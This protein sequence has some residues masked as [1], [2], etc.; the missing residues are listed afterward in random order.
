[1]KQHTTCIYKIF[2]VGVCALLFSIFQ[3]YSSGA[4][5]VT[6]LPSEVELSFV[7]S[8]DTSPSNGVA[9]TSSDLIINLPFEEQ[10]I[11]IYDITGRVWYRTTSTGEKQL[12]ISRS[13][14]PTGL[15]L[16]EIVSKEKQKRIIKIKL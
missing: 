6:S 13:S 7:Q 10:S 11:V 9:V 12:Y 4:T 16:I 15:V 3:A 14:L 5:D 1:M 8:P 2:T